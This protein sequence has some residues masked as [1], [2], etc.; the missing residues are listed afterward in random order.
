[1]LAGSDSMQGSGVRSRYHLYSSGQGDSERFVLWRLGNQGR[2]EGEL[3][4]PAKAFKPYIENGQDGDVYLFDI[5]NCVQRNGGTRRPAF[6]NSHI[7]AFYSFANQKIPFMKRVFFAWRG[8]IQSP[9][10][11]QIPLTNLQCNDEIELE[12]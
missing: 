4:F 9:K 2:L 11:V 7:W 1:M 10:L 8:E 12:D 5:V 6:G 3:I